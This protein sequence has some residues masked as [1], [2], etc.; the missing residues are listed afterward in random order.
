MERQR[1]S[2]GSPYEASVGCSRAIRIDDRI[3]VSGTAPIWPDGSCDPDV[4]AQA[5][6]CLEIILGA[7]AE[8]GARP[9]DV[10]RTRM[11]LVDA[12]DADVVSRIHGEVFGQIRPAAT[13][14]VVAALV[15]SRGRLEME[16]EA[17]VGSG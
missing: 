13:I 4:G 12:A 5:R 2:S 16:A 15:D 9:E 8:G 11:Y 6:R 3:V 1:I 14:V 10:I 17:I 7:L